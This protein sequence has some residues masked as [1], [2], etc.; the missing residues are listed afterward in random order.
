MEPGVDENPAHRPHPKTYGGVSFWLSFIA[1]LVSSFLSALDLTA[2]GTALPT[3]TADLNGQENFVWI[4]SAYALSSTAFLPLSG[5][6]ADVFGRKPVMMISIVFFAIGSALA[7]AAQNM[8]ML[9]AARTIEGIGGGGIIN[10]T[11]IIISDLVPLVDR[12][13]YQGLLGITWAF[14]SA[15]GPPIGGSLAEKASWRWLFYINLPLTGIAIVVVGLYLRIKTPEG[16]IM[17]KLKRIDWLGNLIGISGTTLAVVGLTFAGVRFPWSSAQA[18]APLIIGMFLIFAFIM[19]E[20]K[21]PQEPTIAWEVISNRTSFCGH[22]ATM[23]HGMTSVS[24]IYYL[25]IYFQAC[26]LASPIRSGVDLFPTAFVMSPAAFIA[27]T[28][29]TTTKKYRPA[30]IVGWILTVIG[31]GVL[32]L[33]RADS[34]TGKW[35]GYQIIVTIGT[36]IIYVCTIFPVLAPLPVSRTATALAFFAFIRTFAQTW[37]IT[38]SSTILQNELKK[39]LPQAFLSQFPQGADIAISAIPLIPDLPEP[40]QTEVRTAFASSMS[41]IW[42]TMIGI[43][44]LGVLTLFGLKEIPMQSHTDENY[45]LTEKADEEVVVNTTGERGISTR[46]CY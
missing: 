6:L 23:I 18:L 8:N 24:I 45:G 42:K 36:G 21:V 5:H 10:L 29:V 17:T 39:N 20:R 4:G 32:S 37:G 25:P 12:G 15:I 1:V 35:V 13:R 11:D 28:V 22:M 3:I 34:P 7:G 43:S 27:G 41:V 9:I 19:Y 30:N 16:S 40:L 46:M 26:L 44:G 33:L 2:V 14:A 38:I 31:F